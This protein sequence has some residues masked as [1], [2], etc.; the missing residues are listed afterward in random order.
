[1]CPEL[2]FFFFL[3]KGM[4]LSPIQQMRLRLLQPTEKMKRMV[5]VKYAW[6][7]QLIAYCSSVDILFP[8]RSVGSAYLSVLFVANML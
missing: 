5:Y 8:V 2:S 1:M 7:H 6:T 3:F 4:Q